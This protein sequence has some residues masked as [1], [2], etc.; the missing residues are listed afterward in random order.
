MRFCSLLRGGKGA[1]IGLDGRELAVLSQNDLFEL[2]EQACSHYPQP[3]GTRPIHT[4]ISA[5]TAG[6]TLTFAAIR[7]LAEDKWL[8]GFSLLGLY[9]LHGLHEHAPWLF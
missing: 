8:A 1:C 2:P 9:L 3:T 5:I 6:Q 4:L 7:T